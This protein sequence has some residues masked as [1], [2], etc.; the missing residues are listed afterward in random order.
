MIN[1]AVASI[2]RADIFDMEETANINHRFEKADCW[3]ENVDLSGQAACRPEEFSPAHER[4][5]NMSRTKLKDRG[6]QKTRGFISPAQY[7]LIISLSFSYTSSG[8]KPFILNPAKMILAA[9]TAS[10]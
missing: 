5:R 8:K 10:T 7:S 3:N 1:I 4:I 6:N 2:T 9:T